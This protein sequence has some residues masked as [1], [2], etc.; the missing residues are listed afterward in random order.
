V[1]NTALNAATDVDLVVGFSVADDHIQLAQSVFAA[2][3]GLGTLDPTASV[4]GA[5]ALNASDR[6]SLGRVVADSLIR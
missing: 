2:A 6:M 5:A 1:F 3:G 4:I